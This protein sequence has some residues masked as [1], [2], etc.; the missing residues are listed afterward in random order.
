MAFLEDFRGELGGITALA[1]ITIEPVINNSKQLPAVVYN[2]R[3][4]AR[5]SY[6]IGSF[7]LRETFIQ[8]DVYSNDYTQLN[9]LRNAIVEHFNGFTGTLDEDSSGTTI[10]S[11][12][13]V[14]TTREDLDGANPNT[15]RSTI[16]LNILS[17]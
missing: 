6:T 14:V 13:Q 7:G 3:G 11:S 16:E 5:Q 4:L 2:S 10:V 8:I 12:C 9:T 17:S 15:Y 1:D